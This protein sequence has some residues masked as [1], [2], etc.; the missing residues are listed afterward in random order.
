MEL[1]NGVT[2][3]R[4]ELDGLQ[5]ALALVRVNGEDAPPVTWR[6]HKSDLDGLLRPGQNVFEVEI[7][8]TLRNLLGPHHH[9]AGEPGWVSPQCFR[10]GP[11]WVDEY[12]FVPF[13]LTGASL[14]IEVA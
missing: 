8:G 14:A 3:A 12:R 11:D 4:L 5:G 2:A 10:R 13:G 1:P 7:V 9:V 6:P